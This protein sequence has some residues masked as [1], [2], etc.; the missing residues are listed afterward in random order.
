MA[1]LVMSASLGVTAGRA[2]MPMPCNDQ[3]ARRRGHGR[4]P[5]QHRWRGRL[6]WSGRP[7]GKRRSRWQCIIERDR[8]RRHK[9][10]R[11]VQCH[12][13]Q[14][15]KRD[16]RRQWRKRERPGNGYCR[17]AGHDLGHRN[18]RNRRFWHRRLAP[19]SLPSGRGWRDCDARVADLSGGIWH[20]NNRRHGDGYWHCYGGSGGNGTFAVGG[21]GASVSLISNGGLAMRLAARP[22]GC[23]T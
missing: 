19:R 2:E 22:A 9:R 23:S 21:G 15:R 4:R 20:F 14:R 6:W 10:N 13:R 3:H 12:W 17:S 11:H 16:Q 18:R 1:E 5:N 8:N 7:Q